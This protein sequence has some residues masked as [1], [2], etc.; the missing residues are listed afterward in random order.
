VCESCNPPIEPEDREEELVKKL[1]GPNQARDCAVWFVTSG[2]TLLLLS[3][4]LGVFLFANQREFGTT[5]VVLAP[6]AE[7][8]VYGSPSVFKEYCDAISRRLELSGFDDFTVQLHADAVAVELPRSTDIE[9]LAA[10]F[11]NPGNVDFKRVIAGPAPSR[12]GFGLEIT[13]VA[14]SDRQVARTMG[15][16]LNP[17]RSWYL[18]IRE[19]VLTDE[20]VD[21]A[22]V[23]QGQSGEFCV[24]VDFNER[25]Q[26][27]VSTFSL[28]YQ[29]EALAIMLNGEVL[30]APAINGIITDAAEICGM[31]S[32]QEAREIAWIISAGRLPVVLSVDQ[33]V[34]IEPSAFVAFLP[35]ITL[36]IFVIGSLVIGIGLAIR[37]A[38]VQAQ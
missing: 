12:D 10:L 7:L 17:E 20:E 32:A 24:R 6:D 37:M 4:A 27:E 33:V 36:C 3:I 2:S 26:R 34:N 13:R 28:H 16:S 22:Y 23:V 18:M 14:P 19:P 21:R 9:K 5:L 25:G 15:T 1:R 35:F 29:G 30:T 11:E 31:F 38:R 8:N